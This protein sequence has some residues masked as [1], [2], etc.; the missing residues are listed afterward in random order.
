[1]SACLPS[2]PSVSVVSRSACR[3]G[4]SGFCARPSVRALGGFVVAVGFASS[5]SAAAFARLWAARLPAVC[6]GCAV[7]S[8]GGLAWVSV[9]VLPAS[10]PVVVRA[11]SPV[12]AVGAPPAVRSAVAGGGV[13]AV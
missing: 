10:A 5:S 1:M 9:P 3:L 11:G 6:C 2:L 7:R 13:W 12:V 4:A 8:S